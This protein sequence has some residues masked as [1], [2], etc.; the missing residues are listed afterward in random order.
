[1]HDLLPLDYLEFWWDG[2]QD[3]FERRVATIFGR[4]KAI[5]TSTEIGRARIVEELEKRKFPPIPVF[6]Y[7]LPSPLDQ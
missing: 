3:I 6:S 4:A 5:I 7:T 1:M 2:H